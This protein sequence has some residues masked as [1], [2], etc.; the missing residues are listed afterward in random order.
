M[1]V[2]TKKKQ[3]PINTN[4]GEAM[5]VLKKYVHVKLICKLK[6]RKLKINNHFVI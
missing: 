6:L 4:I 2:S 3:N 5:H 1:F